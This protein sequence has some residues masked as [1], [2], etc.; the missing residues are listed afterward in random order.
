VVAVAN[1]PD[2]VK[3]SDVITST[4]TSF[5]TRGAVPSD[6]EAL[7]NA[8]GGAC[9]EQVDKARLAAVLPKGGTVGSYV[10]KVTPGTGGGAGNITAIATS[11]ITFTLN[12][13]SLTLNDETVF[14]VAPRIETRIDFYS[15]TEAIPAAVKTAVVNHVSARVAFGS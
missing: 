8:K 6:T 11:T 14:L 13:H 7:I 4:A 5:K 3:G 2:Y 9:L 1:S 15:A 12:H 10:V